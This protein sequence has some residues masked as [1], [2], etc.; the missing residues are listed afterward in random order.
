MASAPQ[1]VQHSLASASLHPQAACTQC[2]SPGPRTYCIQM[3]WVE[4]AE[5]LYSQQVSNCTP[6]WG[7]TPS[8]ALTSQ[9]DWPSLCPWAHF[10][11]TWGS[12]TP[13]PR[14][15]RGKSCSGA[16]SGARPHELMGNSISISWGGGGGGNTPEYRMEGSNTCSSRGG[17][18]GGILMNLRS[19]RVFKILPNPRRQAR[20][21]Q[22]PISLA[23]SN[24]PQNHLS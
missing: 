12:L 21:P 3:G 1:G 7:S 2:R 13:A 9:R 6:G 11:D 14:A 15:S 24:A 5:K 23:F 4:G 10:Q 16:E 18:G 8:P 17:G 19:Q 20:G 22:G